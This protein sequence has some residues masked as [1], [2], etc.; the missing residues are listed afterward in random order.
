M[1]QEKKRRVPPLVLVV[2]DNPVNLELVGRP[3]GRNTACE[4]LVATTGDAAIQLL[5]RH[6]RISFSWTSNC[7]G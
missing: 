5:R 4:T 2:E 7:Q 1:S 3:L 6:T